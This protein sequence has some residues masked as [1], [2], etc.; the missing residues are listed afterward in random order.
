MKAHLLPI[1]VIASV[2][3]GPAIA[4]RMSINGDAGTLGLGLSGT[5]SIVPRVF[6]GRL[7]ANGG[8][9]SRMTTT[10]GLT[11]NARAHFRN[12]ALLWDY[13]PFHGIFRLIGGVYYDDNRV[14]L[15]ATPVNGVYD[16]NGI[17]V[18]E[19]AV[20]PVTGAITYKRFAPYLGLGLSNDA[21]VRPGWA[22]GFDMGVL[23][24]RPTTTLSAPGAAT[25]PMLAAELE[26]VRL[27]IEH[28][29]NR[30]KAYPVVQLSMGYRF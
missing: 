18:P 13:Y 26:Q 30:V 28:E 7:L 25:N 17:S 8:T 6:D 4:A 9:I 24:D 22:F 21:R 27:Q 11:Y 29:A 20:G 5:V 15:Q 19:S 1:G 12:A 10:S 2:L 3:C 16:I 23:W 14:N